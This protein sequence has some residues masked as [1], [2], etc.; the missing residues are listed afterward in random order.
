MGKVINIMKWIATLGLSEKIDHERRNCAD[1]QAE[2]E[3]LRYL[4]AQHAGELRS[5]LEELGT[6]HK[7]SYKL[8]K[9]IQRFYGRATAADLAILSE[10]FQKAIVIRPSSERTSPTKRPQLSRSV[11]ADIPAS[12]AASTLNMEASLAAAKGASLG[13]AAG[14]GAWGLAS[15]F[16]T[17]STGTAIYGL[18]G[19]AASHATLAWFGGGALAAGGSGMAGGIV[20]LG[21]LVALPFVGFTVVLSY[22]AARKELDGLK[23]MAQKLKIG[24]SG[25]RSY[26][27]VTTAARDRSDDIQANLN[28]AFGH[29]RDEFKTIRRQILPVWFL[30]HVC[31]CIKALGSGR[32]FTDAEI[33]TLVRF[34]NPVMT[35]ISATERP[36]F[37]N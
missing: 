4:A 32:Y 14:I 36:V 18:S 11:S 7:V 22:K 19:A 16:G 34:G 17:A 5:R 37:T 28:D 2:C 25:Y 26:I 24:I 8:L 30:S 31:R 13:T 3:K 12:I 21:G 1:L 6:T 33:Q 29:C 10:G 20:V 23:D 15:T 35:L 9:R 27:E